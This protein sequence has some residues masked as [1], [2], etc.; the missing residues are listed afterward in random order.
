VVLEI[1]DSGP[2][3]LGLVVD[4]DTGIGAAEFLEPCGVNRRGKA[5]PGAGEF[6]FFGGYRLYGKKR[7]SGK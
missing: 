1:L 7:D 5:G 4:L 2:G 3:A 6:D